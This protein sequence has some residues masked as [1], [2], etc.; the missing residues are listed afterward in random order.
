M[1][2]SRKIKF[3][4]IILLLISIIAPIV[5]ASGVFKEAGI[6][7][8][9][10]NIL[11]GVNNYYPNVSEYPFQKKDATQVGFP[12]LY[13]NGK[14]PLQYMG[15]VPIGASDSEGFKAVY[16]A[17]VLEI[18]GVN[19]SWTMDVNKIKTGSDDVH[20]KALE[21]HSVGQ[22]ESISYSLVSFF[23]NIIK[24]PL[25][26]L[27]MIKGLDLKE[28][29]KAID[30]S[31]NFS[32][33]FREM[34][35]YRESGEMSPI[36]GFTLIA[37]AFST[38]LVMRRVLK[39]QRPMHEV[40]GEFKYFLIALF[41]FGI[42]YS[43]LG[44]GN[45]AS[46]GVN[47]L[48]S[49]SN[50]FILGEDKNAG[51][52]KYTTSETNTDLNM[53]QYSMLKKKDVESD[54]M[55]QFGVNISE[56]DLGKGNFGANE[57]QALA[58][59]FAESLSFE[60]ALKGIKDD[61]VRKNF[62]TEDTPKQRSN[63][64]VS[65]G[66]AT[67]NNLG[68]YWYA[69]NSL[70]SSHSISQLLPSNNLIAKDPANG[71]LLIVDFLN[72]A[73]KY[74]KENE[75]YEVV[76]RIDSIIYSLARPN[77]TR[78]FFLKLISTFLNVALFLCLFTITVFTLM[79]N[80]IVM[81]GPF[82]I[83]ILVCM[84]LFNRTRRMATD[85]VKTYC[86]AFFRVFLGLALFNIMITITVMLCKDGTSGT[87]LAAVIAWVMSRKIPGW[88]ESINRQLQ[89]NESEYTRKYT[90]QFNRINDTM[91]KL[92]LA[93]SKK[94]KSGA[95]KLGDKGKKVAK[96][97]LSKLGIKNRKTNGD[98]ENGPVINDDE[99]MD[100][101]N[102]MPDFDGN[103]GSNGSPDPSGQAPVHDHSS[104]GSQNNPITGSNKPSSGAP[105]GNNGN[106]PSG[107]GS[108]NNKPNSSDDKSDKP[109]KPNRPQN[110]AS[111][112]DTSDK[113]KSKTLS[114]NLKGNK[115]GDGSEEAKKPKLDVSSRQYSFNDY[116]DSS[117]IEHNDIGNKNIV[118]PDYTSNKGGNVN[119]NNN[120]NVNKPEKTYK[121]EYKPT[122][123]NNHPNNSS[124]NVQNG[125][126]VS[127]GN[128]NAPAP[129]NTAKDNVVNKPKKKYPRIKNDIKPSSRK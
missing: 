33:T 17:K 82:V 76:G 52:Y 71:T 32:K 104:L 41:L 43:T 84:F 80:V 103:N 2:K 16:T 129:G 62:N 1:K 53:T 19:R 61:K 8:N 26:F 88:L 67:I 55:V 11:T 92:K 81:I 74:A 4:F 65:N 3:I 70:V 7:G 30:D 109:G 75:E 15:E 124:N 125:N 51:L 114:L 29:L 64:E 128:N 20:L 99:S 25:D 83:A 118:T 120:Y 35:L 63:F 9:R 105:D 87:F 97:G 94:A 13:G 72:N 34:F 123:Q 116:N 42:S 106:K 27:F 127:N 58:D 54:I 46:N 44:T 117:K 47:L 60:D 111:G 115:I 49:I 126:N 122:P 69:S 95:A 79:G 40:W 73:R 100:N 5:Y 59:T 24:Y 86:M 57:S 108:S 89:R 23:D 78:G 36:L 102:N 119:N 48:T 18:E 6:F 38:A 96:A 22:F 121:E 68:Y 66:S 37:F 12:S 113:P 45:L 28:I 77:Y 39:G 90:S 107:N 101:V 14:G 85:F 93:S 91:R 56:L 31:G 98:I 110:V 10:F 50:E 112:M 21:T